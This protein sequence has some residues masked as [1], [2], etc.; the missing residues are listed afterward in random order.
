VIS[1]AFRSSPAGGLQPTHARADPFRRGCRATR[2]LFPCVSASVIVL[3][4]LAIRSVMARCE[5]AGRLSEPAQMNLIRRDLE[6]KRC[7]AGTPVQSIP[8]R[9]SNGRCPAA[10]RIGAGFNAG[11]RVQDG[12]RLR[13]NPG[14]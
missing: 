6:K 7:A 3:G 1:R 2:P 12:V 8:A 11:R 4:S 5:F 10:L 14:V 13:A 9:R